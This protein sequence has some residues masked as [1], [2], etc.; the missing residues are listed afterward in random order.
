M[1]YSGTPDSVSGLALDSG[2]SLVSRLSLTSV[3]VVWSEQMCLF[4]LVSQLA[5]AF[6]SCSIISFCYKV[7]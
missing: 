6:C 3:T 5:Q 4:V 1:L 7:L 2:L